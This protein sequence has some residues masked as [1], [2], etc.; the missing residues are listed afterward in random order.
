[1]GRALGAAAACQ[2]L[3]KMA[4]LAWRRFVLHLSGPFDDPSGRNQRRI[5]VNASHSV[6]AL[7][8]RHFF[9]CP[10][11]GCLRITLA[12]DGAPASSLVAPLVPVGI[13]SCVVQNHSK[14]MLAWWPTLITIVQNFLNNADSRSLTKSKRFPKLGPRGAAFHRGGG[15][16]NTRVRSWPFDRSDVCPAL[17]PSASAEPGRDR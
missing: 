6:G 9:L 2:P 5:W 1:M 12:V 15:K 10:G 14:Q 13:V 7:C 8:D 4:L 17:P 16:Y 3:A 11:L